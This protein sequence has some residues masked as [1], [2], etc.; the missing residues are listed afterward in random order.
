MDE[1]YTDGIE[2]EHIEWR[3]GGGGSDGVSENERKEER[4]GGWKDGGRKI[5]RERGAR[6]SELRRGREE[7]G[8]NKGA[9][10]DCDLLSYG[11]TKSFQQ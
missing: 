7:S 3:H 6:L 9:T 8:R 4:K 10:G 11:R 2:E 1:R 5:G